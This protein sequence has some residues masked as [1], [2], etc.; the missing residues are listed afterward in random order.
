VGES[1]DDVIQQHLDLKRRN[2]H[3]DQKL[4]LA[5][6]QRDQGVSDLEADDRASDKKTTGRSRAERRDRSRSKPESLLESL[7]DVWSAGPDFN[8]GDKRRN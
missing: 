1:F 5:N 6:Y 8:W 4:P 3:L 2:S 7:E